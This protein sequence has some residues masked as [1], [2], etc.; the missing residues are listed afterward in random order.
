MNDERS[1]QE[2]KEL[3]QQM[4]S[5][6][7]RPPETPRD[8]MWDRI[9]AERRQRRRVVRLDARVTSGAGFWRLAAAA[10]AIL[11]IGIA[12]G[13]I[14]PRDNGMPLPQ[15]EAPSMDGNGPAITADAA[16][17]SAKNDQEPGRLLY[18]QTAARLFGQAD[19]LLTD[20]RVTTC[21]ATDREPSRSWAQEMLQQT[22]LLLGA[23]GGAEDA[24]DKQL[25]DLLLDL[26]MVLVQI[27]SISTSDCV[28]DVAWIREGIKER[29]T[30]DR[31][32]LMSTGE[33]IHKSL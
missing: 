19:V 32:R 20:F 27:S 28:R 6:H 1:E 29:S 24:A 26:E 31:L 14:I 30:I 16:P 5:Q 18:E 13:R 12:V 9:D 3:V 2:F 10:V 23:A 7:N 8:R 25:V 33:A 17:A 22:R 15:A 21:A 4:S 11:A